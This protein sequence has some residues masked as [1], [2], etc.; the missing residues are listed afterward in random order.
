MG[1]HRLDFLRRMRGQMPSIDDVIYALHARQLSGGKASLRDL[2]KVRLNP[3]KLRIG[4][5]PEDLGIFLFVSCK[6]TSGN[7]CNVE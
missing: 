5:T 4:N 7:H 6:V 1:A 2:W 3:E